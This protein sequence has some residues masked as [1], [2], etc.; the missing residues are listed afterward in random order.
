M[1]PVSTA[2]RSGSPYPASADTFWHDC[3]LPRT[4]MGWEIQPE[5]LTRLLTRISADYTA[6]RGVALYVTENGAAFDDVVTATDGVPLVHDADRVDFL[7]MHLSAVLDAIDHGV[8]VRGYFYWSLLDNYEWAWG[9]EKRFGLVRVD[10]DT[11]ERPVKDSGHR[12]ARIIATA[13]SG[14]EL[15][16]TGSAPF[17]RGECGACSRAR[18]SG[19]KAQLDVGRIVEAPHLTQFQTRGLDEERDAAAEGHRTDHEVEFVHQAARGEPVPHPVIGEHD[20]VS[21][22]SGGRR[23]A[24]ELRA[25]NP[26]PVARRRYLRVRDRRT[27]G[28]GSRVWWSGC[29]GSGRDSGR[30]ASR[31]RGCRRARSGCRR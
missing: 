28:R 13:R 5:G 14:P 17:Q 8:D 31:L 20:D 25:P 2:R 12:Y 11:Q 27:C 10:Y 1:K 30:G 9:Y 19:E 29:S 15:A 4:A 24:A 18:G 21:V 16:I 22:P 23:S 7:Q 26:V 6:E 3:G